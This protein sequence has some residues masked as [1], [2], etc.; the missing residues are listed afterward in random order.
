MP[1]RELTPE[2]EKKRET[3]QAKNSPGAEVIPSEDAPEQDVAPEFEGEPLETEGETTEK[4]TAP[5]TTSKSVKRKK[6]WGKK[7]D[8]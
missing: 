8:R 7:R 4:I 3:F 6:L 2:R 5:N 1:E